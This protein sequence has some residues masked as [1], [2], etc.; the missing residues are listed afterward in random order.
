MANLDTLDPTAEVSALPGRRVP[1]KR[2]LISAGLWLLAAFITLATAVF[3]RTTGPTYPLPVSLT[4]DGQ[5]VSGKLPRTHPGP[6]DQ[7]VSITVPD[8]VFTGELTYRRYRSHDEW[9]TRAMTRDGAALTAPIPHQPPAGKVQY[10]LLL[11]RGGEKW[12]IPGAG[13]APVMIRFRGDV[14][15]WILLIHIIAMF[16]GMLV[17][18]R[19]GLEALRRGARVTGYAWWALGLLL[20][21]G[22]LFG[23]LVQKYA[24]GAYWTGWPVGD[25]LT[26]TK[27]LFATVFWVAAVAA[28]RRG[29]NPRWFVL[30]AAAAVFIIFVIPHSLHGSELDFTKIE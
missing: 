22:L 27:T 3:Q 13:S 10:R 15:A 25:D 30:A 11:S 5:K 19:A 9:T 2:R 6:G 16:F 28:G 1:L 4:I 18:T 24:F 12:E 21:G 8:P 20:L 29:R 17:S 7:P 26:D 23:P 14:P